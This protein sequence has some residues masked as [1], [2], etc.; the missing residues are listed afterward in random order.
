MTQSVYAHELDVAMRLAR[1]AG[2]I[3]KAFYDVPPTVRWKDPTEPV[4]EADRAVNAYLVK[5]FG[6]AFPADGMLAE[7]SKDDL[8]RLE[9]RRG[10]DC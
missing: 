7:E 4:T 1:E 2:E 3:I 8:S 6:Q 9:K 10:L 5:Q